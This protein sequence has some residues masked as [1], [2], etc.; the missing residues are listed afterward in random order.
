MFTKQ[1]PFKR[2]SYS[3][4]HLSYI[5]LYDSSCN[6]CQKSVRFVKRYD[7]RQRFSFMPFGSNDAGLIV[8][9][10]GVNRQY[11]ES[12]VFVLKGKVYTKSTAALL[13]CWHL[14]GFWPILSIF[15]LIPTPIRDFFYDI[16][17]RNR[18]RWFGKCESCVTE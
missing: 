14:S 6:L 12:V 3:M 4:E 17:A 16:I 1:I 13:I 5:I 11:K 7:K 8:S 9:R 15:L 2:C 18:Y 10:Y